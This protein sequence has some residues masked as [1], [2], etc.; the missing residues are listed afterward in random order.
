ML[1]LT[2]LMSAAYAWDHA[3]ARW[4]CQDLP[5]ALAPESEALR[6]LLEDA[7]SPWSDA[8]TP[9]G[10]R[11]GDVADRRGAAADGLSIVALE[12]PDDV[13]GAGVLAATVLVREEG[14][15]PLD[16]LLEADLIFNDGVTWDDC[17]GYA[18]SWVTAH[19]LGHVLGLGHSEDEAALMRSNAPECSEAWPPNADDLAGL[20]WLYPEAPALHDQLTLD[21]TSGPAPLGVELSLTGG[22]DPEAV[23][24]DFGDGDLGEG[25]PVRHTWRE[26][27]HYLIEAELRAAY[28]VR[29]LSAELE[30]EEGGGPGL[31]GDTSLPS[32]SPGPDDTDV[33]L[34][35]DTGITENRPCGC[36]GGAQAG[37]LLLG[38][39]W[40][41]R[42]AP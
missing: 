41:R 42:R 40:R 10:L 39:C 4:W 38:A 27:G 5:V 18:R 6:P 30:V 8:G 21:P 15:A 19:E 23:A 31:P 16:R 32:D 36:G 28:C 33:A 3:G 14:D 20:A 1:R 25:A 11:I 37:L 22:A 34:P 17:P 29:G 35:D 7:A 26:P 9:A 13:L 12:D 24:W 2:L